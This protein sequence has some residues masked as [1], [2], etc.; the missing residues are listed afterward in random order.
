MATDAAAAKVISSHQEQ[1]WSLL[2]NGTVLFEDG[3]L[4]LPNRDR[5][6]EPERLLVS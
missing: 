3:G 6:G 1:G 2:C 5:A 4:L